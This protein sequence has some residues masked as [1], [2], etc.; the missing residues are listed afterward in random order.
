VVGLRGG[1]PGD[2]IVEVQ[3][4]T[5]T[6]LS[7]K[8]KELLREFDAQCAAEEEGFFSRMFHSHFKNREKDKV[9]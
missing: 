8:Q 1:R 2:M 5:P 6:G 4:R 9:V 3:V 7:K